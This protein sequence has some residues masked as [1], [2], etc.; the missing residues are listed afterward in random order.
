MS[1]IGSLDLFKLALQV[2]QLLNLPSHVVTSLLDLKFFLLKK[3]SLFINAVFDALQSDLPYDAQSFTF[4]DILTP[5]DSVAFY[6]GQ[7]LLYEHP[8]IV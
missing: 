1:A 8:L 5:F 6:V 4:E 3:L 7:Q 2:I